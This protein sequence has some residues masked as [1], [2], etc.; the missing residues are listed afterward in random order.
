MQIFISDIKQLDKEY[1]LLNYKYNISVVFVDNW[2]L[3][4]DVQRRVMHDNLRIND[5]VYINSNYWIKTSYDANG[6]DI[7]Y[8]TS[9]GYWVKTFYN[10]D[11]QKAKEQCSN[12]DYTVYYYN[13]E[14]KRTRTIR[15]GIVIYT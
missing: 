2:D 12:G 4:L 8:E 11:N 13:H 9:G 14:G 5:V 15:N 6:Q 10:G 7:M 3:Y 1:I